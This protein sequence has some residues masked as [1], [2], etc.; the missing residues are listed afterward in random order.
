A[1]TKYTEKEQ[2]TWERELLGLYISAHPLDNYDTYFEEQTIPLA[3]M[4]PAIDG[5]KAT[6]GGLV[7]SVRTIVT[8]SGTKMAFVKLEDKTTEA[9]VIIFPNLYEQVGA[10]LVQDAV[11]RVSGKVSA[12]DRDGNLG[13]EAKMIA[14][15]VVVVTDEE[16]RN[17]ESTGRKM[18]TPRMS[19]HVKATRVAEFRAKKSG[20][21]VSAPA[22]TPPAEK[23]PTAEP[24]RPIMDIPPV[25]KLFVH[26]K[27]PDDHDTL[28]ELKRTCSDFTGNTDIILV[29]GAE[30]KSAIK[31]PFKVDG[32]DD[33]IS[34]LVK[35]LG[36]DCVVLK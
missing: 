13:D 2:L 11:I 27:E 26:V 28:M 24:P 14:D 7:S 33:L 30:K 35:Q 19:S 5:K 34:S 32:S 17:Y 6:I 9:E 15:E 25:K 16:L 21:Q 1:P 20:G 3:H 4:K 12:R 29:L 36:E 22:S 18:E 8:K 10:K 23:K 31:L